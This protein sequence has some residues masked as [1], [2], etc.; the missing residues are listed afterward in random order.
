MNPFSAPVLRSRTNPYL[1]VKLVLL[2][3]EHVYSQ[4]PPLVELLLGIRVSTTQ[5]SRR[6]QAAAQAL[7]AAALDAPC[8]GVRAGAGPIYG[9][10]RWLDALHRHGVAGS[11]SRPRLPAQCP[12]Q[13]SGR[14]DKPVP[15]RGPA[16]PLCHLYP[17]L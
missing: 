11:H 16:E 5:G 8:P 13:C 6:T 12:G 7:P 1:Q 9:M 4:V 15:I 17:T 10:V 14:A 2:A 3:A